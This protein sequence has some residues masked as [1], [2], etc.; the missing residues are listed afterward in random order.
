MAIT[1]GELREEDGRGV[2]QRV[3]HN[4]VLDKTVGLMSELGEQEAMLAAKRWRDGPGKVPGPT[5]L[6]QAL[7]NVDGHRQ[8]FLEKGMV[9]EAAFCELAGFCVQCCL[10]EP[11]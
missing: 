7:L 9:R 11:D 8:A 5:A 2:G 6:Q 4:M 3:V 1:I 10:D